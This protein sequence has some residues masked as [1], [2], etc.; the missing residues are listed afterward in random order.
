[1]KRL[2]LIAALVCAANVY[3]GNGKLS[4]K[5]ET[6]GVSSGKIYLQ[7]FE[8]KMFFVIDSA[9][10]TK[11]KFKFS[12]SAE[13]PEIYG[14]TLDTLKSPYLLF[15][16]T[17]PVTIQ[18][19]TAAYYR[20]TTVSG[21]DLQDLFLSYKK[22]RRVKID[23]FIRAHP[24]SLVSA[25]VLY[26]DYSYRL[27]AKE[28]ESNIDLLDISL[29]DTPYVRILKELAQTYRT[30]DIGKSAPDFTALDPAGKSVRLSSLFGKGYL[31]IDFWAS[32]C[33]PCRRENPNIVK[34]YHKYKDRGFDI[35]GVSL[36][37]SREGWLKAIAAD[38]LTWTHVSDLLYW[39]SAPAQL[40]GVRA[41]PA[42]VLV[43]KKGVIVAKNLRGEDLE[44]IL[45]GYLDNK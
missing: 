26:R 37:R 36:D 19:D 14:L 21:S 7:K 43:D 9:R 38:H 1:M 24:A 13:L 6:A 28:I 16:D 33:G 4:I 42:N 23:D 2:M 41:I 12:R 35:L 31:L 18:L 25:Y 45:G 34:V 27:S 5:G 10:I 3:A 40:Y 15:L 11:G 44:K 32:W 22:Q 20:N 8:N 17:H 29:R 30:V 39:N